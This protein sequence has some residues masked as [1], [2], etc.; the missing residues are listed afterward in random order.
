MIVNATIP[1]AK[2]AIALLRAS[3]KDF[4]YWGESETDTPLV[5]K[6]SRTLFTA[7]KALIADAAM[8]KKAT[9]S[10]TYKPPE[11]QVRFKNLADV[12]KP[13]IAYNMDRL[14]NFTQAVQVG[15][16][17]VKSL[18]EPLEACEYYV[19]LFNI[20]SY[21]NESGVYYVEDVDSNV[22]PDPY[23]GI[24]I[25]GRS[26]DGEYIWAQGLMTKTTPDPVY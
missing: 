2:T 24:F 18:Q 12:F 22:A 1:A 6:R 25:F 4:N 3:I 15:H 16:L 26:G 17:Q 8:R 23:R 11:R 19:Q 5:T 14:V 10:T 20:F 13:L 9:G 7:D 21:L